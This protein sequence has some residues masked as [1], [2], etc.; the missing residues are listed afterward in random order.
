MQHNYKH[1]ADNT[2]DGWINQ[3]DPENILD[4]DDYIIE[5][6]WELLKNTMTEENEKKE[7]KLI[8]VG[9]GK[10]TKVS[11]E[12][13]DL[14]IGKKWYVRSNDGYVCRNET[15]KGKIINNDKY[16]KTEQRTTLMHRVIMGIHGQ[17]SAVRYVVDH[18]N[19]DKLDNRRENLRVVTVAQ[20]LWNVNH[21]SKRNRTGCRG[22][23][24]T[25]KGKFKAVITA[26]GKRVY[27]GTFE[28][29]DDAD[30]AY[31]NAKK[32]YHRI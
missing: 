16:R 21:A 18:I 25:K 31:K 5:K 3:N 28:T 29:L 17:T 20:N 13:F 14:L 10:Y 22:V 26:N 9:N 1:I 12:D 15:I 27:L 24:K 7:Y 4:E 23:S 19:G 32:V 6:G 8:S 30:L 2:L 11:P